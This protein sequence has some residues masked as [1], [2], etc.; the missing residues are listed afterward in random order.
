MDLF[1][2]TADVNDTVASDVSRIIRELRAAA[3]ATELLRDECERI[4]AEGGLGSTLTPI[5]EAFML[6]I[7]AAA[8]AGAE[9]LTRKP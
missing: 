7:S 8:K 6:R 1:A 5:A 3:E 2:S 4:A 9:A